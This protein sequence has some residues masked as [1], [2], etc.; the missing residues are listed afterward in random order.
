MGF[1]L[2]LAPV[3]RGKACMELELFEMNA[4]A[5]VIGFGMDLI[6][7]DPDGWPHPVIWIGKSISFVEKSYASVA[8]ICALPTAGNRCICDSERV[9]ANEALQFFPEQGMR[10]FSMP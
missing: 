6:I 1:G 5:L 4:L 10:I 9:E 8:A 3:C 2:L 7:G